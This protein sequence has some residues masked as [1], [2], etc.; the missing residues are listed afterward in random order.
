MQ[1]TGLYPRISQVIA[2]EGEGN[3]LQIIDSDKPLSDSVLWPL[4]ENYYQHQKINAWDDMPSYATNN[5]LIAEVY[6]DLMIALFV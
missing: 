5:R 1:H 4:L 6:A 2:P 3:A